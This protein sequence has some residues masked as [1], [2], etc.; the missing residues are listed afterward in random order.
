MIGGLPKFENCLGNQMCAAS[1]YA[2]VPSQVPVKKDFWGEFENIPTD[3][4]GYF[5]RMIGSHPFI[6]FDAEAFNRSLEEFFG[7]VGLR[8][9]QA[10]G[11]NV[12]S[13]TLGS[14]LVAVLPKMIGP[15][16]AI[17]KFALRCKSERSAQKL[18][19]RFPLVQVIILADHMEPV[20][21]CGD[22]V[23]DSATTICVLLPE[24]QAHLQEA[25]PGHQFQVKV[26]ARAAR[27][28]RVELRVSDMPRALD[29]AI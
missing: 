18:R 23:I 7:V 16:L 17:S 5:V 12:G 21:T 8:A 1:V 2:T 10:Q 25:F 20:P 22:K 19:E 14:I 4:I 6:T 11:K 9:V 13:A 27:I 24:L 15:T 3:R 26:R 28:E 29:M